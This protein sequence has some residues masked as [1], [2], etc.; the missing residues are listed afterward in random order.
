MY[1]AHVADA[2]TGVEVG[3]GV[4]DL[5]PL[6]GKRQTASF[7]RVRAPREIGEAGN[8]RPV[9]APTQEREHVALRVVGV[10]PLETLTLS[11]ERPQRRVLLVR[12]VEVA[13][14]LPDAAVVGQ[15]QQ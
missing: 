14:Q 11:V 7:A 2:A 9:L 1:G 5:A 3:V 8:R 6:T 10:D 12:R 15:V 13:D 4:D